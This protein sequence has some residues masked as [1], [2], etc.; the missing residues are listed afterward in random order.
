M[1]P[2]GSILIT[3]GNIFHKYEMIGMGDDN[4]RS[5]SALILND[6]DS[7]DLTL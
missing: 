4:E 1:S 6:C 3:L 5:F 7:F 2:R